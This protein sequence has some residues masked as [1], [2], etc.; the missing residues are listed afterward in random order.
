MFQRIIFISLIIL[1]LF[2]NPVFAE[3]KSQIGEVKDSRTTG[4]FFANLEIQIKLIGDDFDSIVGYR[5]V[6]DTAVDD[7]GKDL[8]EKKKKDNSFKELHEYQ[9]QNPEIKLTFRNPSRK[10]EYVKTLAGKI[11][12]FMP[13]KDPT[14]TVKIKDIGK[15]FGKE[16]KSE[17]LKKAGIAFS[18]LDKASYEKK[19]QEKEA[20]AK[21]NPMAKAL[22]GMF[23]GFGSV[24]ENDLAFEIKDPNEKIVK[25]VLSDSA[26]S[27]IKAMSWMSSGETRVHNYTQKVPDNA[28][29]EIHL[30]TAKSVVAMPIKF[31]DI[32][33]P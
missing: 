18:V 10:A 30:A 15:Q 13:S 17:A 19:K 33:L 14:A 31:T 11:E 16:I 7:T 28:V 21:A 20:K 27:E 4:Q 29:L 8:K 6:I 32:I 12:F 22:S 23:G 9:R 5:P 24:G 25:Y 1:T 26:G 3:F 2:V